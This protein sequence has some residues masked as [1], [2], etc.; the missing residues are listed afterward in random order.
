MYKIIGADGREYGPVTTEQLRQWIREGRASAQTKV[1]AEGATE[2]KTLGDFS[3]F[4][5]MLG[6]AGA[7]QGVPPVVGAVD[8]E[9]LAAQILARDY[10]IDIGGCIGRGWQLVKRDFWLLIGVSFV[11]DLIASGCGVPFLGLIIGGPMMGGVYA[12]YLKRIRGQPAAFGDAFIGFSTAFVPLMLAMLV[13]GL[14]TGL[15]CLLCIL[16]GIYLAVSWVF[17]LPLVVDKK[18]DFWPAMELSRKVITKHWWL[19][20]GFLIV[21]ALVALAG[22]IACCVGIFVSVAIVQAAMMYA[23]E[24]IFGAQN[25]AQAG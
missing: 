20:F 14:L 7:G 25:T 11:G 6:R 22:L 21:C 19:M 1:Q 16:P 9:A 15:G 17:A 12:L 5:D 2:W 18:I 3:E 8:P 4:A 13:K 10:T 23:Y 24:D